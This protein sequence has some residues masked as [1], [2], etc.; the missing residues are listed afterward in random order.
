MRKDILE[1]QKSLGNLVEYHDSR[2]N[3][4]VYI[5]FKLL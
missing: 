1:D 3:L 5:V 4:D 2:R